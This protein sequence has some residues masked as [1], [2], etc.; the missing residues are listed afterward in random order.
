M[1]KKGNRGVKMK[2][3]ESGRYSEEEKEE[4]GGIEITKRERR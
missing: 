4:E 3:K 1:W 2:G